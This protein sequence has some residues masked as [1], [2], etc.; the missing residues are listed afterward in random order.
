VW[1]A[2]AAGRYGDAL[3]LISETR[4]NGDRRA[5]IRWAR[6]WLRWPPLAPTPSAAQKPRLHSRSAPGRA[7]W[8][9]IWQHAKPLTPRDP[10][11][12]Y[13][14]GRGLDLARLPR[15]PRALRY[16]PS[17]Y[18]APSDRHW[19]A[20]VAAIVRQEAGKYRLTGV[21]RT[22]LARTP[23]AAND[24]RKA[25]VDSPKMMLGEKRAGF[26]AL[27]RGAAGRPISSPAAGEV[28]LIA[29][30]IEDGLTAALAAPE[31]RVIVALDIGNM[32]TI[33]LPVAI[34]EIVILAQ[35]D[36]WWHDSA[37]RPAPARLALEA[38]I[39]H[40]QA[41]GRRVRL[42]LPPPESKDL[43]AMVAAS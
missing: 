8:L 26:V 1:G 36:P 32:A 38:A 25:P 24:W 17:L 7:A 2:W 21:H 16:H 22:F 28:C 18:H 41:Q 3:T 43:N 15:P 19:P 40:F 6:E 10:V 31:R 35:R 20:M 33:E 29:E 11:W 13:L 30:G 12:S 4:T 39:R 34:A 14:R 9:E 23:G 42:A 5:A 27:T 37:R